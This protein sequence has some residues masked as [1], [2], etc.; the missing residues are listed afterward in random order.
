[1]KPRHLLA[2]A[3]LGCFNIWADV[4]L[5]AL[6]SDHMVIQRNLPVLVWGRAMP[7]ES[8]SVTLQSAS[9]SATADSIGYWSVRLPSLAAGGPFTLTVKGANTITLNDVLVGDVWVA[10]GQSNMELPLR[11]AMNAASEIAESNYPKIRFLQVPDRTSQYPLDDIGS[12]TGWA[13]TSPETSASLSAVAYFF[14]RDLQRQNGVP[15]GLLSSSWG[16][17][18]QEAWISL[19]TISADASL[20]PVF[21][22]WAR[23]NED[24]A[25][26]KIRRQAQ[27]KIWQEA[28]ETAKA[29]GT[30]APGRP[31]RAN[32]DSGEW[33]PAGLYNAMIAPLTPFPIRGVIWYQGESNADADHVTIYG[34]LIESMIQDWRR[35]WGQGDFPFLLVQLTGFKN[36]NKWPEAREA[37]RKALSIANTGL[38]VT[39]DIGDPINIHP[40]NKQEV[41]RRLALIAR[42]VSDG[43]KLEYSGPLF[44]LATIESGA[45]RVQFDHAG[46]GLTARGGDLKTFEVAGADRRFKPG[47]ARIDG[48]TVVV[49]SASVPAP[50]YVRYAWS[51]YPD[52]NL[53]NSEGLPASPFQ[54][55]R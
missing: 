13:V 18:P 27:L 36:G 44:R 46:S 21:S 6:F 34:R 28:V 10:S 5:P 12:G 50:L 37:Q 26:E 49:S 39:I 15:I 54:S 8:V 35:A 53:Y 17:T 19:K 1:M 48:T 30:T 9:A 11:E 43:E 42:A 47:E 25:A 22:M 38:A 40:K 3:L 51:D 7:G 24:M 14:A 32:V 4:S 20:I 2:F 55:E 29:Q 45:I 31:W 16:G 23:M 41:G 52:G 33:A